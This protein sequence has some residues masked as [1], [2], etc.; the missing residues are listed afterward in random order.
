MF[1]LLDDEDEIG[2]EQ[3]ND[4]EVKNK[5]EDKSDETKKTTEEKSSHNSKS[6]SHILQKSSSM[7]S[8]DS[9]SWT[10]VSSTKSRRLAPQW[11]STKQESVPAASVTESAKKK[12]LR[13]T[14]DEILAMRKPSRIIPEML[15]IPDV[16]SE[17]CLDPVLFNPIYPDEVIRIW[18]T[19]TDQVRGQKDTRGRGRGRGRW[20]AEEEAEEEKL[21]ENIWDD[22]SNDASKGMFDLADFSAA[23]FKF[24]SE[25]SL[26]STTRNIDMYDQEGDETM[27]QLMNEQSTEN[28]SSSA[29][30]GNDKSKLLLQSLGMGNNNRQSS[31]VSAST[32][33]QGGIRVMSSENQMYQLDKAK[34]QSIDAGVDDD[35]FLESLIEEDMS[36]NKTDTS[37]IAIESLKNDEEPMSS[38]DISSQPAFQNTFNSFMSNPTVLPP[39][40]SELDVMVDAW[41]YRDPQQ[42]LQGPFET[43]SMRRWLES[44]YFK[45]NLPIKLKHWSTFYTLG[46]AYPNPKLAF[47][48]PI[49]EPV[50]HDSSKS[51]HNEDVSQRSFMQHQQQQMQEQREREERQK[52]QIQEQREREERQKQQIQQQQLQQQQILQQQLQQQKLQQHL[53]QEQ[54]E[55]QKLQQRQMEQQRLQNQQ[56]R[57]NQQQLEQ[58]ETAIRMHGGDPPKQAVGAGILSHS[59]PSDS[60]GRSQAF[61]NNSL[62]ENSSLAAKSG[63]KMKEASN[64]KKATVES[65]SEPSSNI[66]VWGQTAPTTKKSM[67]EIQQE[68]RTRAEEENSGGNNSNLLKS[69][70]GVSS[71]GKTG[72]SGKGWGVPVKGNSGAASLR[73]IQ[74][75]QKVITNQEQAALLLQQQNEAKM[76]AQHGSGDVDLSFSSSQWKSPDSNARSSDNKVKSLVDIMQEEASQSSS[77]GDGYSN[78]RTPANSW[79]ARTSNPKAPIVNPQK[80][81]VS[82]P[83]T[84]PPSQSKGNQSAPTQPQ[85]SVSSVPIPNNQREIVAGLA[86]NKDTKPVV[87]AKKA[88]SKTEPSTSGI[89]VSSV[90]NT[91]DSLTNWA[92][93]QLKNLNTKNKS[94]TD[95]LAL[96]QFCQILES[97]VEIREYLAEYLGSTPEVSLFASEFIRRKEGKPASTSYASSMSSALANSHNDRHSNAGFGVAGKKKKK[98]NK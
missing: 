71:G 88:T 59:E 58:Q 86:K 97:A 46:V 29:S 92:V 74:Q 43:A 5:E 72:T 66:P 64:S 20:G 73:E 10:D 56:Q 75:E 79:A 85:V 11:A 9:S 77:S 82:I 49:P 33:A 47:L 41:Y 32:G 8:G 96:I 52:Q 21:D 93:D 69:L 25:T 2:G 4:K 90:K 27:A 31:D 26:K 48:K 18:N 91:G 39:A 57:I 62:I 70:L 40:P 87:S 67:A 61:N 81:N 17:E 28:A 38:V 80:R 30:S 36:N 44:G 60:S 14:R 3:E 7:E 76:R 95:D 51:L 54:L 22:C 98:H 12:V 24:S 68:E 65:Q 34:V 50:V 13:Y 63:G 84:V 53:M 35:N 37:R 78:S 23:T 45:E 1:G 15:E 19:A 55:Q 94:S 83:Q 42:N 6:D 16:V 89:I